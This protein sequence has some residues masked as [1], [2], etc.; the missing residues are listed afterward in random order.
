MAAPAATRSLLGYRPLSGLIIEASL[1]N[2]GQDIFRGVTVLFGTGHP[3]LYLRSHHLLQ[4][5]SVFCA[6]PDGPPGS[7]ADRRL[8]SVDVLCITMITAGELIA[9]APSIDVQSNIPCRWQPYVVSAVF[10]P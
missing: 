6:G 10:S 4:S 5:G 1:F 8:T 2:A 9:A 7:A 3:G